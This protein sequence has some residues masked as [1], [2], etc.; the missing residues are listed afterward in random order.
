MQYEAETTLCGFKIFSI[1]FPLSKF[2][3]YQT[4]VEGRDREAYNPLK[5]IEISRT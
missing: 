3:S 1:L 5:L 2:V 4:Y